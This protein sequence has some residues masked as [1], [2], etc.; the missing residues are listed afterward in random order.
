MLPRQSVVDID[1][2]LVPSPTGVKF[3]ACYVGN[4]DEMVMEGIQMRF[5]EFFQRVRVDL[6]FEFGVLAF[7]EGLKL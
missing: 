7:C 2:E 6:A 5:F 3:D 4:P 1:V